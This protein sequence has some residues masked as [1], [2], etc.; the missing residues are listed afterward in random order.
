MK[1]TSLI[2]VV[3]L[4]VLSLSTVVQSQER[5]GKKHMKGDFHMMNLLMDADKDGSVSHEEFKAFRTNTFNSADQNGDG[6]LNVQEM[7]ELSS[8]MKAQ[9]AKAMEMAQKKREA[10]R[11][12]KHFNKLDADD[13]GEVSRE[14][15]DAKGERGFIRMDHNDDGF[16]NKDDRQKKMYK[17]KKMR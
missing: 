1:K 7:A 6:K 10:K 12:E 11:A 4:A 3:S 9:K 13:N 2:I 14:E 8:I 5:M 15:F 16:L 17:M